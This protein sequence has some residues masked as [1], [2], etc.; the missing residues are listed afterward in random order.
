MSVH[1]IMEV[2]DKYISIDSSPM[3]VRELIADV[4]I[5]EHWM[6]SRNDALAEGE[7][8]ERKV[9]K[10]IESQ[11]QSDVFGRLSRFVMNSASKQ[12]VQG[13]AYIE[14][15]DSQSLQDHK[16]KLKHAD[17]YYL[18]FQT[19]DDKQFERLCAGILK[20]IGVDDPRITPTTRDEGIDF[21]GK[22]SLEQY[23]RPNF[24]DIPGAEKQFS[25]WMIGQAKHFGKLDVSTLNIR[26]LVGSA[27]LARSRAYSTRRELR[28]LDLTVRACDAVYCLF[29]TTGL[30]SRDSWKLLDASGVI[31]M[32]GKMVAQFL[33]ERA[34]ALTNGKFDPAKFQ[35]WI[36]NS[37]SISN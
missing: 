18:A 12:M 9:I 23:F 11:M 13:V 10:K 3:R 25:V 32:D 34:I 20:E 14:P 24:L 2:I 30:M 4:Y 28:Y 7:K 17:H 22:L 27:A 15:H 37:G 6:S 5:G 16:N 33:A 8:F 21:F 26:E 35:S 31:G 29:F 36:K 1:G 19:L